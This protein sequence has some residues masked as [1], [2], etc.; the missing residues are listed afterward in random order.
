MSVRTGHCLCGA[1]TVKGDVSDAAQACHCQQCQRWTGGGPHFA[2]RIRDLELTGEDHVRAYNHSD[3]GQRAVC[4]TCGSTL[5]WKMQDRPIAFVAL[6]LLDDQSG[7]TITEEIFIDSRPDW[8]PPFEG[9][10]QRTEAEMK[11]QLAAFL[12][13]ETRHDQV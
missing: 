1:V 6:G 7:I 4:D 2:V 11:A 3:W 9:A 10:A 8:L 13:K 12:E 5:F